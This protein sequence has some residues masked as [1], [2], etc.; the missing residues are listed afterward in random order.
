VIFP[1]TF[2]ATLSVISMPFAD[3]D[4]STTLDDRKRQK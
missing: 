1:L 2:S 4:E 3:G